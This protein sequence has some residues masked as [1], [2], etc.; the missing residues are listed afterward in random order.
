[1]VPLRP[2]R[3]GLVALSSCLVLAAG[4]ATSSPHYDEQGCVEHA[5]RS[6]PDPDAVTAARM[7]FERSCGQGRPEACSALGVVYE[8]GLGVPADPARAVE[9]YDFAC[10]SGN[11]HGCTNLAVARV[12][13]IGGPRDE[14]AGAAVLATSCNRGDARACLYLARLHD[15]G[16]APPA[17]RAMVARLLEFACDGQ[18]AT[19]CVARAESLARA[20]RYGDAFAYYGKACSLGDARAC[21]FG[22]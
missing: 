20:G 9:L 10:R 5:L 13:G 6:G 19:A 22:E 21:S 2:S 1:V 17:E 16:D 15:A 12:Q 14:H 18:E 7:A 11:L 8:I 4:C 3:R